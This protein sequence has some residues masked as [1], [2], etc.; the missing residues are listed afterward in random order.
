MLE[1]LQI[2]NLAVIEDLSLV[3][4]PGFNVIT[5]ETGAGKSLLVDALGLALGRRADP[6]FVRADA[7]R[8]SVEACFRLDDA[9]RA[10]LAPLLRAEELEDEVGSSLL[11]TRVIRRNGRSTAR[12]NG[13]A[14]RSSL[15]KAL[16]E[17][18]VD[19]H[20][21]SDHLSLLRPATHVDLLDRHANLLDQRA[22]VAKLVGRL[23]A[24]RAQLGQLQLDEGRRERRAEQ[25]RREVAEIEAVAPQPDED[26]R[27][28]QERARLGNSEQLAQLGAEAQLALSGDE[29]G[30]ETPGALEQ[31][32]QAEQLLAR[33]ARIDPQ[34][35]EGHALA[36]ALA[37]QVQELTGALQDY[38]DRIE[39]NPQ[40][41]A[42]VEQ[43]L[44]AINTLRRRFGATI[45]A[46]LAHADEAR[47]QL[48]A[49]EHNEQQL[50]ACQAEENRLLAD[51]GRTASA[52]SRARREAGQKLA[53][54]VMSELADLRMGGTRFEVSIAQQ[55]SA[56]GCLVEGRR[57]R[58]DRVGIDRLQFLMSANPGQP[59][60]PLAKVASGGEAARLM[61]ALK[62]V[63][64]RA[65]RTPALIFDE[66][67]QGIGGRV[68]A[69]AGYK[70][71][72]LGDAHQV[73]AVTHLAQLAAC[74]D[75]HYR[76]DKDPADRRARATVQLL[77]DEEA[78]VA[79]LASMLGAA[80]DSGRQTAR[81]LLQ[82]AA[83][84]AT[85]DAE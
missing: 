57:L 28:R 36:D 3:F 23:Q 68:G 48:D 77:Q 56:D 65:D 4:G 81:E 39:H 53:R 67:D 74:A 85:R 82:A 6:V 8:A 75:R 72:A 5:G 38:R 10:N 17:A 44:E 46:V 21:Q 70:L 41:L 31:L 32:M 30:G 26:E 34:L 78:R 18:M 50:L 51:L 29:R 69:V 9:T 2:R 11:L 33:L 37:Q 52:L 24:T 62:H 73:L 63:L 76:V 58:F 43:R 22:A 45:Q 79:E 25:L 83:R 42:D 19:I 20:G 27:L 47:A 49:L 84:H 12:V 64:A 7:E 80:G 13:I 66:I 71:R 14:V 55:E 40:R 1:E 15:L 59:P 35:Q 54:Q 60:Q 61:L 16:G